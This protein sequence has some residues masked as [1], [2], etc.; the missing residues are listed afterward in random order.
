MCDVFPIRHVS[1]GNTMINKTLV[2][3]PQSMTIVEND[4]KIEVHYSD[5]KNYIQIDESSF[6]F[7]VNGK[8]WFFFCFEGEKLN[9]C[10]SSHLK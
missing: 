2:F 6:G 4:T 1:E 5:I 3:T 8:K 7:E 9:K 10:L